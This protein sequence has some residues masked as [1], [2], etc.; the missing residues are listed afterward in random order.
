MRGAGRWMTSALPAPPASCRQLFPS[1]VSFTQRLMEVLRNH[2][3]DHDIDMD[4]AA[5]RLTGE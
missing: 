4:V 1:V 2:G 5:Q 3:P